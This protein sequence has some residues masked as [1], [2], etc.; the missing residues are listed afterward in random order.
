LPALMPHHVT[1]WA[2]DASSCAKRLE[3][4]ATV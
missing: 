1:A 3:F 2:S 4:W